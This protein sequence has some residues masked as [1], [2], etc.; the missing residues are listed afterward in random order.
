MGVARAKRSPRIADDVESGV[1]KQESAAKQAMAASRS[2]VLGSSL[3]PVLRPVAGTEELHRV[4]DDLD[5]LAL[6][7]AVF[8]FPL[9]PVEPTFDPYRPTLGE[10]V[11]AVPT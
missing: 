5:R 8:G 9:A 10:V 6:A 11:R 1:T 3:P 7:A 2:A 4:G